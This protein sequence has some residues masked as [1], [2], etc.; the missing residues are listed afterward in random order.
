MF[1]P[2]SKKDP[3]RAYCMVVG[4]LAILP[5]F[6]S[7][8][9]FYDLMRRK[10]TLTQ[11]INEQDVEMND[12]SH[13]KDEVVAKAYKAGCIP[14]LVIVGNEISFEQLSPRREDQ[15]LN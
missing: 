3:R 7:R 10:T 12:S 13:E 15:F 11:N 8:E 2:R 1:V 14:M 4:S 9:D 6:S 5:F